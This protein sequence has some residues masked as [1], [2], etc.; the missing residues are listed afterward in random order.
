MVFRTTV[1]RNVNRVKMELINTLKVKDI[2][3]NMS[4]NNTDI[5]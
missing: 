1:I 5:F 2:E 4:L 3:G